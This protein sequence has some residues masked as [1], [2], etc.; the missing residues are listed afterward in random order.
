VNGDDTR[1]ILASAL[2]SALR[3]DGKRRA[4]HRHCAEGRGVLRLAAIALIA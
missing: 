4:T 1:V 3:L 2:L